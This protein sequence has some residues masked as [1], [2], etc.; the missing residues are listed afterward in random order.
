MEHKIEHNQNH[1]R[2]PGYVSERFRW[3]V[4]T[5]MDITTKPKPKIISWK[6]VL[7]K[8]NSL[9]QIL[10]S[11]NR[12]TFPKTVLFYGHAIRFCFL[13]IFVRKNLVKDSQKV[14]GFASITV[15]IVIFGYIEELDEFIHQ[16]IHL[17]KSHMT[18][19]H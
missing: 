3:S 15:T 14:T 6:F 13:L 8:T 1:N 16:V 4:L 17:N 7:S 18:A 2:Y 9:A 10:N 5:I 19:F 12:L 11:K